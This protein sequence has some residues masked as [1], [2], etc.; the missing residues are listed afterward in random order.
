[1]VN[2]ASK[3]FA[4]NKNI[5][6]SHSK[7]IKKPS[8]EQITHKSKYSTNY[9]DIDYNV[10]PAQ[11]N[12]QKSFIQIALNEV[13]G[14]Q[15]Y[16]LEGY[17]PFYNLIFCPDLIKEMFSTKNQ[18]TTKDMRQ[19]MMS[20][21]TPKSDSCF[22]K[23]LEKMKALSSNHDLLI[24]NYLKD[25]YTNS[26]NPK[27]EVLKDYYK[28]IKAK[29]MLSQNF[30]KNHSKLCQEEEENVAILNERQM[31][32]MIDKAT[33][34]NKSTITWHGHMD[35]PHHHHHQH[36]KCHFKLNCL[37]SIFHTPVF[38]NNSTIDD[39]ERLKF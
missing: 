18:M 32:N 16:Q 24:Q 3:T 29:L 17:Q 36:Q 37:E 23:N 25:K 12:S 31:K 27:P 4:E 28:Y 22:N 39:E 8:Q 13:N 21:K 2:L 15:S 20:L 9:S 38:T 35:H 6:L 5:L 14:A 33:L 10:N 19:K 1:M 30:N 11:E 34:T 7:K 26:D